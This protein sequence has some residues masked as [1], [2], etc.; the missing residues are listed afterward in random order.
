MSAAL[1]PPLREAVLG[2]SLP[3]PTVPSWS[4]STASE[5]REAEGGARLRWNLSLRHAPALAHNRPPPQQRKSEVGPG[6][7][8]LGTRSRLQRDL[9][10][11]T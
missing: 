11:F 2:Y 6:D 8:T 7:M 5:T 3:H 9:Q 4:G 10:P 1:A